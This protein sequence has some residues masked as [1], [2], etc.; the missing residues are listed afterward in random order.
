MSIAGTHSIFRNVET[1]N[2]PKTVSFCRATLKEN[3]MRSQQCFRNAT[4][5][6][7]FSLTSGMVGAWT[8][9][10]VF[11]ISRHFIHQIM[12]RSIVLPLGY[13]SQ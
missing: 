12:K 4:E 5:Q 8:G 13:M 7:T 2:C 3:P 9:G 11:Y 6:Q 10:T 1:I